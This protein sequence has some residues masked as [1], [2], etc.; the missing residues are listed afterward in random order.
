MLLGGSSGLGVRIF[1]VVQL[2]SKGE[3]MHSLFTET[4]LIMLI[5]SLVAGCVN[6]PLV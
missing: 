6:L 1:G 3:I 5:L 2:Y 4:F